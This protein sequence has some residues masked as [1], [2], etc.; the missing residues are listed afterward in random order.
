M[1]KKLIKED[2]LLKMVRAKMVTSEECS[3]YEVN[4]VPWHKT[5]KRGRN[6]EVGIVRRGKHVIGV[7]RILRMV[8]ELQDKYE[9][10]RH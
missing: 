3:G 7:S 6:W 8:E 4:I 9:L 2:E 1:S 5:D 10:K